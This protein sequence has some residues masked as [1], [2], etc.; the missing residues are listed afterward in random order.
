MFK[1]ELF[2]R[3]TDQEDINSNYEPDREFE[4]VNARN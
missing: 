3:Q 4:T 2:S 1:N